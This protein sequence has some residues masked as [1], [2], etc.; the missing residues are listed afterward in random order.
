MRSPEGA[1]LSPAAKA[2]KVPVA[3]N[4]TRANE[5]RSQPLQQRPATLEDLMR[6]FNRPG[7]R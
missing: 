2:G 5:A 4:G 3:G 6:K 1:S 7:D